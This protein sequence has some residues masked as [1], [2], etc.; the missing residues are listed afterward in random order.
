LFQRHP[1]KAF[2][3]QNYLSYLKN[4][5]SYIAASMFAHFV[6][7]DDSLSRLD[8]TIPEISRPNGTR[9]TD[10]SN[11]LFPAIHV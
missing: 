2:L 3:F 4:I 8:D 9:D 5:R 10:K 6:L 11:P 7:P 1:L